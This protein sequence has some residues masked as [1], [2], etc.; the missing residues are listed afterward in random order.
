M[1]QTFKVV[2]A[3]G[4]NGASITPEKKPMQVKAGVRRVAFRS[5]AHDDNKFFV[6]GISKAIRKK[7][8]RREAIFVSRSS[9]PKRVYAYSILPSDTSKILRESADGSITVGRYRNGQFRALKA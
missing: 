3:A 4:A 6:A 5:S 9:S 8:I 1:A 7:G 2:K